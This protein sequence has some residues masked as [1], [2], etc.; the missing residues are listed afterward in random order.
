MN[1]KIDKQKEFHE[2]EEYVKFC[3]SIILKNRSL[4]V[5]CILQSTFL[6]RNITLDKVG[7]VSLI[8]IFYVP[9]KSILPNLVFLC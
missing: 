5:K 2:R 3:I 8:R 6:Y 4:I 1:P 9:R 7:K